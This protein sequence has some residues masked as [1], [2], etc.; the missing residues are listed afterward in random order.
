MTILNLTPDSFY[1]H[2]QFPPREGTILK[3][4]EQFLPFT[5]IFD[6]G[7]VS[8]RPGS[9]PVTETEELQRLL[10]ILKSIR[11]H[12]PDLVISVDTYRSNVAIAAAEHGCDM[13][14]DVSAGEMDKQM[15][16]TMASLHLPYII[17]HMK[18]QPETMQDNPNYADILK[19]IKFYF[20]GKIRQLRQKGVTDIIIDPGFGF[21]KTLEDNYLILNHL[22]E[23]KVFQ[24]PLLTGFSRKS[25]IQKLLGVPA[26][27]ALPGTIVLNTIALQKGVQILRVHDPIEA[28]QVCTIIEKLRC[29]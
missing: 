21:G 27:D 1:L 14:N 17:M 5:D 6:L 29:V 8:T 7:A 16:D 28:K 3:R 24:V 4:V 12:F 20:A 9:K 19:E 23:F 13:I 11:Q 2:E 26:V 10:P 18:G 15:F 25:M 22:E